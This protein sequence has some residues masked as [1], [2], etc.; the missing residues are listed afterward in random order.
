MIFRHSTVGDT[1]LPRPPP[2]KRITPIQPTVT[3][4]S[5]SVITK[6]INLK[7]ESPSFSLICHCQGDM[8]KL[9]CDQRQFKSTS[10]NEIKKMRNDSA[11]PLPVLGI[12]EVGEHG[13]SVTDIFLPPSRS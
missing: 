9:H 11:P 12:W 1:R 4:G 6:V 10:Q 5:P 7:K 3:H 8:T 13:A 2:P